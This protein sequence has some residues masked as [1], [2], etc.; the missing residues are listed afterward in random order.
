MAFV[1]MPGVT[2]KVYVPD[3]DNTKNKGKKHVCHDCYY[4]QWC[5]DDRCEMCLNR[6]NCDVKLNKGE[7][8]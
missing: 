6:L 4:C 1:E 2:G 3:A 5:S 8:K 7:C